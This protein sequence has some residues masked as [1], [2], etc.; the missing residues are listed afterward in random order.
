MAEILEQNQCFSIRHLAV[1]GH[2][3]LDLGI[4]EGK[5]IGRIL[6]QLLEA[7][8]DGACE[9]TR[10]SLLEQTRKWLPISEAY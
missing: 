7:V 3:L 10:P 5:E 9:N 1:N 6:N 2:D 8:M 4:P